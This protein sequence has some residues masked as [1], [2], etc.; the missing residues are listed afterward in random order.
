MKANNF[1][2]DAIGPYPIAGAAF[3][4]GISQLTNSPPEW[5][6]GAEGYGKRFGSDFGMNAAGATTRYG[7]SELFREDTLYYP[8]ECKGILPRTGHAMFS[9]VTA[10][11]GSDGHRSISI[12]AL[13]APYAASTTGVYGWYPDRYGAKDAFRM[14]NYSLLTYVGGKIAIEFLASGPHS[15]LSRLHLNNAHGSPDQ[16][17]NQ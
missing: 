6:Q 2:F 9:A 12:S 13:L 3:A 14:G 10:R 5:K 8:C 17:P 7:L 15:L 1:A 11:H 16:G 4:A